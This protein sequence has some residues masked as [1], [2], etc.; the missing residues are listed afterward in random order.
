[1]NNR[2]KLIGSSFLIISVLLSG[3]SKTDS[4]R[5]KAKQE[6]NSGVAA[7]NNPSDSSA[8]TTNK[9]EQS[10]EIVY[11]RPQSVEE[12]FLSNGDW[13][14][15]CAGN[16]I[17]KYNKKDKIPG[18]MDSQNF[19]EDP[20]RKNVFNKSFEGSVFSP[21]IIGN[22]MYLIA[23][24]KIYKGNLENSTLSEVPNGTASS[25]LLVYGD[26]LYF[27]ISTGSGSSRVVEYYKMNTDGNNKEKLFESTSIRAPYID[28]INNKAFY[29]NSEPSDTVIYT[30]D[31]NSNQSK[32]VG[33]I[34][35]YDLSG[36]IV[37][38]KDGAYFVAYDKN[39]EP[40]RAVFKLDY[41]TGAK[42][43]IYGKEV[44]KLRT[45]KDKLYFEDI[46]DNKGHIASMDLDGKNYK[47]VLNRKN[48]GVVNFW[49]IVSDHLVYTEKNSTFSIPLE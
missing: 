36:D 23:N 16:K 45:Y 24:G 18:Y 5:D 9:P 26:T 4:N 31:I 13:T 46:K 35:K 20:L 27:D 3:C 33:A 37:L 43:V 34:G 22:T 10:K 17:Y 41:N 49:N 39:S 44:F 11:G 42:S 19:G 25:Y 32:K 15:L 47:L 30:L 14:Y 29:I 28:A 6:S 21:N 40:K 7:T 12:Y 48:E 38:L 8:K 2:L 1:M